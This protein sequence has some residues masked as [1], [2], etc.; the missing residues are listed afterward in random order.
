[1][2]VRSYIRS[3]CGL[4]DGNTERKTAP[5]APSVAK[6][7][8]TD[9][10]KNIEDA[11]R[12]LMGNDEDG[13]LAYLFGFSRGAFTV[14]APAGMLS[15][16]GL[17]GADTGNLVEYG[18]K[19]HT[20]RDDAGTQGSRTLLGRSCPARFIGV[21]DTA[22]SLLSRRQAEPRGQSRLPRVSH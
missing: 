20:T 11:Y 5:C 3:R 19:V 15:Q 12:S 14:R 21:W 16:C 2:P 10:I 9:C 1:M 13:D 6:L 22:E 18:S 8:V 7:A 4:A 17:L